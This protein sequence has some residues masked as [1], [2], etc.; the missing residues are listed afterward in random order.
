LTRRLVGPRLEPWSFKKCRFSPLSL[1]HTH[2]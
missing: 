2:S 1:A